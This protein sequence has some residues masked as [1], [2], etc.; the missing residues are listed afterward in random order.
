MTDDAY[1]L[2]AVQAALA[3]GEAILDVYHG[4]FAVTQ[5]ADQSPLTE[6]DTRSHAIIA[7]ALAAS[8]VPV[9][10][11]EG[12]EIPYERRREWSA[13]WIVD[14]LD[15]TK[16]F[17]KRNGEFTVNI[18]WVREGKPEWGVI[19]VP[20]KGTLYFGGKDLGAYRLKMT[21][22]DTPSSTA[23]GFVSSASSWRE[24]ATHCTKLAADRGELEVYT[25]VGSRSHPSDALTAFVAEK[26]QQY[27]EVAFVSAGSSLK[28]CLLAEGRAHIYPRLGPT[29]EWDTAAGH[30]I[31]EGAGCMV[32]GYE[33]GEPLRY[34]KADLHN[35]WFVISSPLVPP[36][37]PKGAS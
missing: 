30:A 22:A 26:Q 11:E 5:K 3:A 21:D 17:V 18:A 27:G 2:T 23:S 8:D 1:I 7:D 28:F 34:N 37:T 31:A 15:G 4:D 12:K 36:V 32:S 29:M 19:V 6:A 10:S 33:G 9:L 25:I 20:E 14:P 24:L 13:I 35:P 16:E